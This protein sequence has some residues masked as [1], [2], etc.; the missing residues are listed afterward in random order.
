MTKGVPIILNLRGVKCQTV[1]SALIHR[2]ATFGK[3]SSWFIRPAYPAAHNPSLEAQVA[4]FFPRARRHGTWMISDYFK[5]WDL[6][7]SFLH[8]TLWLKHEVFFSW[9]VCLNNNHVYTGCLK[10]NLA[11]LPWHQIKFQRRV[12][13]EVEKNIFLVL[14]GKVG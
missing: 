11:S 8:G 14:P 7:L 5:V 2:T 6:K 9:I 1:S 3:S 4:S 10:L 12:W 13:G